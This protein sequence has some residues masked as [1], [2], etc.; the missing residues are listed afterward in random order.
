MLP[1]STSLPAQSLAAYN[2]INEFQTK[3]KKQLNSC[4]LR[5]IIGQVTAPGTDSRMTTLEQ[6]LE[7]KL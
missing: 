7:T 5:K 3:C 4:G 2:I 6:H 1:Q